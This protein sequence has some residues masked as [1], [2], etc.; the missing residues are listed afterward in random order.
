MTKFTAALTPADPP[1][2]ADA[3][4]EE[5]FQRTL[6]KLELST[7]A[8]ARL[9]GVNERTVR[10]WWSGEAPVPAPV[11]RFLRYLHRAKISPIAVME[12]LES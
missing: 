6:R 12:V 3:M 7:A 5:E 11:E 1:P 10:R 8:A 9:V 2:R 4:T